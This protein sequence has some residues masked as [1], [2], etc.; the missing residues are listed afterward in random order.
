LHKQPFQP[1]TLRLVDGRELHVPHPD[2]VAVSARRVAVITPHDE[3][4][5][6]LEP[7]LMVSLEYAGTGQGTTPS[8]DG[9]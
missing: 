5:A 4:L 1:F 8:G 9:S 6:L 2:F 3:S 7:L